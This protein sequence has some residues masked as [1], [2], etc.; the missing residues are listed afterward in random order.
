M[1]VDPTHHSMFTSAPFQVPLLAGSGR[2]A[3]VGRQ[4]SREARAFDPASELDWNLLLRDITAFANSGGGR[5]KLRAGVVER[6]IRRRLANPQLLKFTVNVNETPHGAVTEIEVRPAPFPVEHFGTFYFRHD[7]RSEPGTS[8]DMRNAYRRMLERTRRRLHR[9]VHKAVDRAIDPHRPRRTKHRSHVNL[10]PVR[11]VTDPNAPALHPEDVARLYPWRQK[12]LVRELNQRIGRQML[13]SYDIQ[14]VRRHHRLDER[15]EFVFDLPGA[16][17][18]YSPATADWI[19][20]EFRRDPE[21]FHAARV[22]DQ[23]QLKLRRRKPK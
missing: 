3:R 4:L 5:I 14:A 22:A 18:R 9:N 15:P 23:E 20:E 10:Q 19:M 12:E 11:I 16:G 1:Q 6:D 13:N 21:F 2:D 17:R 8:A 7:D